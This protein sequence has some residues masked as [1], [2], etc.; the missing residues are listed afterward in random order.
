[1]SLLIEND[2]IWVSMPKCASFSIEH[3]LTSSN[4][5]YRVHNLYT[6]FGKWHGHIDLKSLYDEFGYRDTICVK[7]DWFERWLSSLEYFFYGMK[8]LGNEPI[9]EW[10]NIDNDFI[11]K[12]F[13]K[14][15][16]NYKESDVENLSLKF[17]KKPF[18]QAK[19]NNGL[20]KLFFSQN[21]W[22]LNKPC[23]YEFNINEL[24]KLEE[25][26]YNRYN[27]VIK[28]EKH[29]HIPKSKNNIVIDDKLKQFVW[30]IFEEP[31]KKNAKLL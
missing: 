30:N 28:I 31:F 27:K 16:I 25:F 15:Y 14:D 10:E 24:Y 6:D 17:L 8:E 13:D 11:Y 23:T 9:I 21:Y 12:S 4:L 20:F 2:L 26:I 3:A 1:M 7:R 18:N 5:N 29:N 19:H 22:K